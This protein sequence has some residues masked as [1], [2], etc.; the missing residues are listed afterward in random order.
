MLELVLSVLPLVASKSN[1]YLSHTPSLNT[2]PIYRR[3]SR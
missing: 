2:R 1:S 3:I